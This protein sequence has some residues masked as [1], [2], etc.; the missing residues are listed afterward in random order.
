MA[1]QLDPLRGM[2]WKS[3]K[4]QDGPWI[5]DMTTNTDPVS[6]KLFLLDPKKS[7]FNHHEYTVRSPSLWKSV[8]NIFN[9]IM[10]EHRPV[11]FAV[12]PYG[13][14]DNQIWNII[15]N[16]VI[17]SDSMDKKE[18]ILNAINDYYKE[19]PAMYSLEPSK[20]LK[21]S[22][23]GFRVTANAFATI[24]PIELSQQRYHIIS[25]SLHYAWN[26]N[27]SMVKCAVDNQIERIRGLKQI[28][29][30]NRMLALIGA[31]AE[32]PIQLWNLEIKLRSI[33]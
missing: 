3:A 23:I 12:G 15:K 11:L 1:I 33:I 26:H 9:P 30:T 10:C 25:W 28:P 18:L 31:V 14:S 32:D 22:K 19:H 6:L 27:I 21:D 5:E 7:G 8:G 20:E 24:T 4:D 29:K 17:M 16:I 2:K 13:L